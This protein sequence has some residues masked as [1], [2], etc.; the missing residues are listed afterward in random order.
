MIVPAKGVHFSS[1]VSNTQMGTVQAEKRQNIRHCNSDKQSQR[2]T[3]D[4]VLPGKFKT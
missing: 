4:A 3:S 1:L 2:Q